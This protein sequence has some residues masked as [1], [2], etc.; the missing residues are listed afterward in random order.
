[1]ETKEFIVSNEQTELS[2]REYVGQIRM[3][4]FM[5]TFVIN[6]TFAA[7]LP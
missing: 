5:A 6:K 1:M 3:D 4:L 7:R 2:T